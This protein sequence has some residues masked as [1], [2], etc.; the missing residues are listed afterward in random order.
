MTSMI[1]VAQV[2]YLVADIERSRDFY[3]RLGIAFRSRSRDD[4]EQVEAWVSTN[5]GVTIVLHSPEFAAWWD[6]DTP[7]PVPGDPE[8]DLE[9]ESSER[10]DAIVEDLRTTKVTIAKEPMNMS[11][12]QR[13]AIVVDPD[14]H[15]IG[16]KAPLDVEKPPAA[17]SQ[18]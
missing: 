8:V 5:T 3:Q 13:F 15:R 14:G 4:V 1:T 10:L 6:P 9:L 12:G 11:W 7:G 16:L 18:A 17:S 2:N